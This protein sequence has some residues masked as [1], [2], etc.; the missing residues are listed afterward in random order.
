MSRYS[1][2]TANLA[3]G[4]IH[5]EWRRML[6]LAVWLRENE[7]DPRADQTRI[8]FTGIYRPLLKLPLCEL[9]KLLQ[10][11]KKERKAV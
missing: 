4:S 8:R 1:D 6:R 9:K 10:E 3:I 2:P 5:R 7:A 11:E